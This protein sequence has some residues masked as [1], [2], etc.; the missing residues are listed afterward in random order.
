[1]SVDTP[2][3]EP[4]SASPAD[5]ST[6]PAPASGPP[7]QPPVPAGPP[8]PGGSG[9]LLDSWRSLSSPDT[10]LESALESIAEPQRANLLA[11]LERAN[12]PVRTQDGALADPRTAHMVTGAIARYDLVQSL[13]ETAYKQEPAG[14]QPQPN[15]RTVER[16]A[17]RSA[18]WPQSR[19]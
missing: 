16:L 17:R 9:H 13:I 11:A 18:G 1:M 4:S 8:S 14:E 6:P 7:W 3:S 10:T 2:E 12:P 15:P 19:S 5:G